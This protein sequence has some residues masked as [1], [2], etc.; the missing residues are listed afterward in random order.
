M[1]V[2]QQLQSLLQI[3]LPASANV[4][5]LHF[6]VCDKPAVRTQIWALEAEI[7]I[8]RWC[9]QYNFAFH[10]DCDGFIC[11]ARDIEL[12]HLILTVDQNSEPHER[13]LGNLLGYPA[14]CCNLIAM[15]GETNIDLLAE[16]IK[17]WSFKD[18]F[19]YINPKAYLEGYAL[20]CHLPCSAQCHASLKLAKRALTFIK[21]NKNEL[22]CKPFLYWLDI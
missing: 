17:C 10:R 13:E 14:C 20:I 7:E 9:Q 3:G 2:L 22:F 5:F 19:R 15:L 16:E 11:I 4:D 8:K 6:L 21:V 18:Q 12:A 1:Q